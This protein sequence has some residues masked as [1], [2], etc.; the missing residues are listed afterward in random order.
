[1]KGA[2]IFAV[3]GGFMF[4]AG[5]AGY[6]TAGEDV[7]ELR[8]RAESRGNPQF[9]SR[10]SVDGKNLPAETYT[11]TITCSDG[12]TVDSDSITL[13]AQ[14]I[15]DGNDEVEFDFDSNQNNI[16]AGATAI[17]DDCVA[18]PL[19]ATISNVAGIILTSDSGGQDACD[20]RER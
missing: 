5:M 8:C 18:D 6:A 3:L 14:D 20:V 2:K 15:S 4:L 17:P 13:T 1:M 10:A 19:I 11:A 9:R 12:S 7:A 16:D